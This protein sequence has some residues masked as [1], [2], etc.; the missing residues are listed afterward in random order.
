MGFRFRV[1]GFRLRRPHAKAQPALGPLRSRVG[2]DAGAASDLG[3]RDWTGRKRIEFVD[4]CW[5][6]Q[7]KGRVPIEDRHHAANEP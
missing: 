4:M 3:A 7:L 1:S 6:S 2:P 5:N